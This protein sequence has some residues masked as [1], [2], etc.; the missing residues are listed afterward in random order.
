ARLSLPGSTRPHP[1]SEPWRRRRRQGAS[2]IVKSAS[3][4]VRIPEVPI[5]DYVLRHAARLG[6]KPAVIDGPTGRTLTYR[7]LADGVRRAAGGLA[8][9]G[10]G[11][12]DVLAIYSPNVPEYAVALLAAASL[13]GITTTANPL[14]TADELAKQLNDAR[15][16]FLLTV[17][18]FLDKAREAAAKSRVADIRTFGSAEGARPFAE[19]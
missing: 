6:D 4:D 9:R 16:R 12:G 14:Y 5:A 3:P 8:A 17:P 19:L 13:G 18:T 15:A 2:M 1:R 11:K 10:F 7:Q